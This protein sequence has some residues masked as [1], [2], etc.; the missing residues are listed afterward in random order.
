MSHS[1]LG[2]YFQTHGRM[3]E[4]VVQYESALE[5]TADP[6]LL[7]TTHA[8]LGAAYFKLGDDERA[9]QNFDE[10]LRLN[11]NQARAWLGLG[12]V[13]AKTGHAPEAFD[14]YQSALKISPDLV[15]AQQAMDAVRQPR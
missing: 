4:A 3:R 12:R 10:S 6:G 11:P 9:R 2:T 1:N 8:N 5:L 15:E 13:L 7:A 14:A